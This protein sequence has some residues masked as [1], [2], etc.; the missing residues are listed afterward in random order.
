MSLE[1]PRATDS[2][3]GEEA[4]FSEASLQ[5]QSQKDAPGLPCTGFTICSWNINGIRTLN[6]K[7]VLKQLNS[8]LILLQE[9]KISS[10]HW[11]LQTVMENYSDA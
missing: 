2:G 1:T 5:T 10:K 9:T 4:E 3:G 11:K 7:D 8:D 6:M